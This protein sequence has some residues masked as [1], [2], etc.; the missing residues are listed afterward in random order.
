MAV[1]ITHAVGEVLRDGDPK[2]RITHAVGEVLRDGDPKVRITHAVGEVL[3]AL[4]SETTSQ[5][6][7]MFLVFP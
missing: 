2:V 1:R 3:R 6:S 4:E 7:S 5:T